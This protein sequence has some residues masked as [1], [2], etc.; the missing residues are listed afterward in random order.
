MH[1]LARRIQALEQVIPPPEP[2]VVT[3]QCLGGR[4][5]TRSGLLDYLRETPPGFAHPLRALIVHAYHLGMDAT[6]T[7]TEWDFASR[8]E[9]SPEDAERRRDKLRAA[10]ER[11]VQEVDGMIVRGEIAWLPDAIREWEADTN[12]R[13]Q[14]MSGISP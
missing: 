3:L 12:P 11:A 6:E 7:E 14:S 8:E 5:F 4:R 10:G 9:L 13:R 2:I 1:R